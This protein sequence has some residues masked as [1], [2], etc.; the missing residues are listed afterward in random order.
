ME[1]WKAGLE[2]GRFV[3][4]RDLPGWD[5]PAWCFL[6]PPGWRSLIGKS[7]ADIAAFQWS[8]SNNIILDHLTRL[9]D[10]RWLPV[11]Y[12]D[13]VADPGE[14]LLRL[15]RFA[16]VTVPEEDLPV[17]PLPWSRTTL[18]APDSGKWKR[19]EQELR[20]LAPLLQ[21]TGER[22]ARICR[23]GEPLHKS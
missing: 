22:I 17:G 5:R 23:Q 21:D 14:T 8:A 3:T 9:P 4:F 6:L 7:Q 15:A 1:A 10:E 12:R 20:A 19:H 16:G 2:T 13:L 11:S 18:T